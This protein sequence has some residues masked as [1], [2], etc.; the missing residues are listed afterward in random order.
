M[1]SHFAPNNSSPAP[2]PGPRRSA[3][4]PGHARA[5]RFSYD[6]APRRGGGRRGGSGV[7]KKIGIVVG[8][9]LAVLL[10]VGGTCG[11]LL[12]RSAMTVKA[13]AS[14]VMSHLDA[15]NDALKSGDAE[16][17]DATVG[18]IQ[19]RVASINAEVHAPLWNLAT[20]IPVVG[21]DVSSVQKLGDAASALVDDALVPIADTVSGVGLS[22]LFSDGAVNV[23]LLQTLSDTLGGSLPAIQSSVD[24]IAAL[25]EAH[26]PQLAE[27]LER[28]QGPAAE[29]QGLVGQAESI[30]KLLPQIFGAGGE[31]TYLVIAQN[32]AEL[33]ALG[34]LPGSWGTI[35]VKDGKLSMG[36]FASVLHHEDLGRQV[37]L[38]DEELNAVHILNMGKDSAQLN[39]LP[40]FG[41]VGELAGE[42]WVQEGYDEVDGTIAIDPVFLQRLLSLTGGFEAP[43]GTT[44]DGTNAAKVLL[45]DTYWKYGNDGSAQDEY[46]SAVAALAFEH[47]M[48]NLGN[49]DILDL[50]D[51]I[52]A[53]S[54]DGRLLVWMRNEDEEALVERLGA[55]GKI[56]LDPA[57]PELGA[58]VNDDTYSKISWYASFY[59]EVGEG[60]RN[61]DGTTTYDVTTTLTNTITD[62]EAAS[63]PR[64]VSGVHRTKRS[65][66]DMLNHVF[67][68]APA[69]GTISNFS[70]NDEAVSDEYGV[71]ETTLYGLQFFRTSTHLEAGE[72][73]V[74][75]Y[76]VT[77][78]AEAT[79]PLSVRTTPLAQ[80][81]LM[82]PPAE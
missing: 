70:V 5:D 38:T 14:E 15:V 54:E 6:D 35:T 76:Q 68:V 80:E 30:L 63:A 21:Q 55:D 22:S 77:V 72:S 46:F 56:G 81:S 27:V 1:A 29:M 33:R 78:S 43:D 25:P 44:V 16:A 67:I 58:F 34:G 39:Y 71:V 10:V 82:R 51:V 8:V 28:V 52:R 9:L 69:G 45:S 62:E 23:E 24:T 53:S 7:G 66:S 74:F 48:D 50:M 13:Q 47:I 49:A 18:D 36:E 32:N 73:A 19:E 41:R 65:L 26:I 64:Y 37:E 60:V 3:G 61:A 12:Y 40:D 75:T 79:E 11:V 17:L 57:T 4:T 42:F 2:A 59:T 31:R 20:I